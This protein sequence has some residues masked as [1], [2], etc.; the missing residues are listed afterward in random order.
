MSGQIAHR[1]VNMT[2]GAVFG[3]ALLLASAAGAT[4][5]QQWRFKVY[6]D[7]REIGHHHFILTRNGINQRLDTRARFEVT[8]LKI[9]FY[10]YRH[11]NVEHWNDSCLTRI[12]SHTDQNGK[13]FQVEGL[14]SE[15]GF[16]IKSNSGEDTLPACVSTFAYW[17]KSFLERDRLLNS[18]TGEYVDI[19]VQYLGEDNFAEGETAVRAHRYRL[20]ADDL[21][22]EIWYTQDG[23]WLA[24][25]SMTGNGDPLRYVPE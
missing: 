1:V 4:N 23:H 5:V 25:Q 11:D 13:Q 14:A 3:L 6:L 16:R 19:E 10:S 20:T 12:S 17:N 18:Q 15:N 2:S 7:D 9:P 24:L 21:D 22:I 8:F